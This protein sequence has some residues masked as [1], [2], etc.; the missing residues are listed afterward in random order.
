[1]M[2][3]VFTIKAYYR[4]SDTPKIYLFDGTLDE[5]INEAFHL[6]K[7]EAILICDICS[8]DETKSAVIRSNWVMK[9]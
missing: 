7:D 3:N 8:S 5:A 2:S 9:V 6:C 1:M 4:M